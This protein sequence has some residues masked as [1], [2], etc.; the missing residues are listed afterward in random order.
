MPEAFPDTKPEIEKIKKRLQKLEER[1]G[2]IAKNTPREVLRRLK[3][4]YEN[5]SDEKDF[6][7]LYSIPQKPAT[8]L[9]CKGSEVIYVGSSIHLRTRLKQLLS[10]GGHVFHN[11]LKE[12]F[13]TKEEVQR[14]PNV[15]CYFRYSLCRD[16]RDAQLLESFC[17]NTYSPK[18]ND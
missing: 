6:T 5:F 4:N 18:Y 10:G 1:K 12:L 15:D 3:Q 9:I 8:Y 13:V 14:F 11:K 17:I 7:Q 2:T 16:E